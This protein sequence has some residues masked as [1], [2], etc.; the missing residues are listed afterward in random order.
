MRVPRI[1]RV[2]EN[3]RPELTVAALD[4]HT[5][6]ARK[7]RMDYASELDGIALDLKSARDG[8][9]DFWKIEAGRRRYDVQDAYYTDTAQLAGLDINVMGFAVV[10]KEPPY[11][12][13]LYTMGATSRLS[14]ELKY[15]EALDGI[16]HCCET[17][18]F[19]GYG[20]GNAVEIE[21]PGHFTA[22]TKG[23]I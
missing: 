3:G 12:C 4:P 19:P 14:G 10:E 5:G 20:G 17:G 8:H 18:R 16:A 1:R 11:V 2:L 15:R 23:V 7:I 9:P 6:L 21:L 22:I 13:G